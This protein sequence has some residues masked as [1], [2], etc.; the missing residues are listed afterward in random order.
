MFSS[1]QQMKPLVHI[2]L[3][4]AMEVLGDDPHLPLTDAVSVMNV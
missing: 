4:G 3:A 1:M 2:C